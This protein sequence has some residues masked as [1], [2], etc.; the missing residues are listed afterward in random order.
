M[1]RVAIQGIKGSYSEEAA[2][3]L[4]GDGASIV[5]YRDFDHTFG[6][7]RIG[8]VDH[9]VIPVMNKIVGKIERPAKLIEEGG[10][11]VFDQLQLSIK[12]ALLGTANTAIDGLT[13]VRS[14]PEALKQCGKFLDAYSRMKTQT[15]SDTASGVR[16]IVEAANPSQAAIGS[17]RAAE[18]YGAAVL[19]EDIADDTDNWTTF[20]V[21]GN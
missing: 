18:I 2:L 12:H 11:K 19:F 10:F 4:F 3:R 9:A 21:I 14:H 13:S 20:Y 6:A 7:L 8:K 1:T 17:V 16:E 5:E 15:C